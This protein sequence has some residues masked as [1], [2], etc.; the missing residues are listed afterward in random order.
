MTDMMR[1]KSSS[2][3]SIGY[4]PKERTLSVCF[5]ESGVTYLYMN[6]D[7]EVFQAFQSANSKGQFFKDHVRDAYSYRRVR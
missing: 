1:V 4:D 2:I 3:Q 5:V 6:V 7:S